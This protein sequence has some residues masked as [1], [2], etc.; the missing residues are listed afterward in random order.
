VFLAASILYTAVVVPAG[1]AFHCTPKKVWDVDGPI[2]CAEGPKLRLHGVAGRE[3]DGSCRP[4]Q[5]CPDMSARD[6]RMILVELL[7][8]RTVS[9]DRWDHLVMSGAVQ[10]SCV[11]YGS[12]KG[13]RTAARCETPAGEDLACKLIGRGA[14]LEWRGYSRGRYARCAR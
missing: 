12:A 10:L 5:P 14:V 2:W 7:K 8:A 13:D 1:T 6:A 9:S 11:S 3:M 4:G